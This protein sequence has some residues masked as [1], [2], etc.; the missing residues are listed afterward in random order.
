MWRRS[1]NRI[2]TDIKV[3]FFSGT[4]MCYGTVMN[5]TEKGMFIRTKVNFPLQPQLRI[6]MPCKDEFLRLNVWVKSFGGSDSINNGLGVELLNPPQKYL[7]FVGNLRLA[8][9]RSK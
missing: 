8:D 2:P 6:L 5:L 9:K 1:F 3:K 4:E 7:E